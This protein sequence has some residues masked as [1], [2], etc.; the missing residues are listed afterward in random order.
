V[1]EGLKPELWDKWF[2]TCTW[3]GIVVSAVKTEADRFVEGEI[4]HL[5]SRKV[6]P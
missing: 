5:A 3:D 6:F 2:D 4:L 1:Q